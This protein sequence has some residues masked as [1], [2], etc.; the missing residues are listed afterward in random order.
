MTTGDWPFS[1]LRHVDVSAVPATHRA[2]LLVWAFDEHQAVGPRLTQLRDLATSALWPVPDAGAVLANLSKSRHLYAAGER[3]NR[4]YSITP[5]GKTAVSGSAR[6]IGDVHRLVRVLPDLV[7]D[8]SGG[9][10]QDWL[11][12]LHP[13]VSRVARPLLESGHATQ[14]VREAAQRLNNRVKGITSR[15]EDGVQLM[16]KTMG[17]PKPVIQFNRLMTDSEKDEQE[18]LRYSVRRDD[19]GASEPPHS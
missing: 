8:S 13:E 11:G 14:A 3:S 19:G 5:K 6:R 10:L 17:L 2:L 9:D 16:H 18:G 4:R 1:E 12:V 15:S 7:D